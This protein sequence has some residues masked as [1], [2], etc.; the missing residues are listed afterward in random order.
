M[1]LKFVTGVATITAQIQSSIAVIESGCI[2]IFTADGRDYLTALPFV[3]CCNYY[4]S[5]MSMLKKI[6]F[7]VIL[8]SQAFDKL[9]NIFNFVPLLFTLVIISIL[10]NSS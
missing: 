2:S 3:V 6:I 10:C 5:R 9:K 4:I 7:T 1:T 8:A